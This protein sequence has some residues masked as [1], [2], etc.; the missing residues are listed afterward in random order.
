MNGI[1][2]EIPK[3]CKFHDYDFYK[4]KGK[5]RRDKI[6]RNL[7]DYKAGKTILE[8]AAGIVRKQ[9]INQLEMFN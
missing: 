6:A 9:N 1:T 8:T 7:V 4:Y 2:N 5:Q 3:W